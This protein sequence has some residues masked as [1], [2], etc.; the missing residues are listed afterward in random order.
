M[1]ALQLLLVNELQRCG[2]EGVGGVLNKVWA[3][4]ERIPKA[5]RTD[6]EALRSA[7]PE[8][9]R[10]ESLQTQH[11]HAVLDRGS[12]LA[13]KSH[14]Q[15]LLRVV[16]E[17]IE[18]M[19]LCESMIGELWGLVGMWKHSDRRAVDDDGVLLYCCGGDTGIV[20]D[21]LACFAADVCAGYA[22]VL[23]SFIYSL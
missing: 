14:E 12:P 6:P 22:E 16:D 7:V 1:C 5:S 21:S 2:I 8:V 4:P 19:S 13:S 10:C 15:R 9:P 17:V 23:K 3:D 20:Y 18:E 11:L